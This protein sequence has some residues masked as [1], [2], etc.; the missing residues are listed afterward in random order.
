MPPTIVDI[1]GRR[2][3]KLTV[4]ELL[5]TKSRGK[6]ARWVC[7]CDCGNTS[8][9]YSTNL[10]RGLTIGCGKC[11]TKIVNQHGH[12]DLKTYD[13][14]FM[15]VYRT[16]RVC[17]DTRGFTF[18]LTTED[19][20]HISKKNCF[21]CGVEPKQIMKARNKFG[22]DYIY[23]GVDRVDNTRGYII[24]NCVPCCKKCNQAK[25]NLPVEEF[26][27]LIKNIYEHWASH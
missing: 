15:I 8:I 7:K 12:Y 26:K 18:D 1:K 10:I 21:Y 14:A 6:K 25:M 3:G 24:D 23:N 20:K 4:I 16:I 13:S 22:S 27:T 19:V 5:D 17:A 9:V 2:F 11:R